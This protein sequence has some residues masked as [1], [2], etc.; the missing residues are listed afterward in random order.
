[1]RAHTAGQNIRLVYVH[2][3]QTVLA[4]HFIVLV[5]GSKLS[6][7]Y[8]ILAVLLPA[9]IGKL[10]RRKTIHFIV[11]RRVKLRL[12]SDW[13]KALRRD[14]WKNWTAERIS[15]QSVC[16]EHFIIGGYTKFR[17]FIPPF[18]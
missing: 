14:D 1:M 7:K 13:I 10:E 12:R 8:R 6:K 18:Q 3:F 11:Y 9:Q 2:A 5:S 16:G 4:F 17:S 15:N